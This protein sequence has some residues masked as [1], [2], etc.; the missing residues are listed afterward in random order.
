MKRDYEINEINEINEK[1][2]GFVYFVHFVY[3][4]ISLHPIIDA[5]PMSW[6]LI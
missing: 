2:R 1:Y 3:F 6:V 5:V 4:V